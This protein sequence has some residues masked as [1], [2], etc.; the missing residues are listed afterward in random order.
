MAV[1]I[2][3]AASVLLPSCGSKKNMLIPHAVSTAAAVSVSDLNLKEGQFEI[4]N[5]I[6]ETASI[7][8]E[9]LGNEIRIIGD[10]FSYR[11]HFAPKSGWSLVRF[12][13]AASLGYFADDV[14]PDQGGD[15]PRPE[16]FAR[17]VAMARIIA[18]AADY[19]ADGII[20]PITYTT[21]SNSGRNAVE[22]TS[23]VR[24]KLISIKTTH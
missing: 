9:Y 23:T 19:G 16:E 24:A 15:I 6:T 18:A 13:G 22:F 17:R 12:S 14:T 3:A 2:M 21:S 20:E 8:C 4:L 10:D 11:F 1:A 5:T 7:T